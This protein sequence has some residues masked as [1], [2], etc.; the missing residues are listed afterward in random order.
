VPL[1]GYVQM[2]P[3]LI[4]RSVVG[5]WSIIRG[6]TI[7]IW[8]GAIV[9]RSMVYPIPAGIIAIAIAPIIPVP[10]AVKGA[11]RFETMTVDITSASETL[12]VL[13][14]PAD[15]P[16]FTTTEAFAAAPSTWGKDAFTCEGRLTV[17]GLGIYWRGCGNQHELAK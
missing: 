2:R 3:E 6:W 17:G 5:T 1:N 4:A 13:R 7:R 11:M 14:F 16:A 8:I 9:V 15:Y 10:A 12:S